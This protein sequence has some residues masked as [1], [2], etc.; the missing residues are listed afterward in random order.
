[1]LASTASSFGHAT[2]GIQAKDQKDFFKYIFSI[3]NKLSRPR[4]KYQVHFLFY[5]IFL[6][7]LSYLVLFVKPSLIELN[8]E[9][10]FSWENGSCVH[11]NAAF[12]SRPKSFTNSWSILQLII[13]IWV[14]MFALEEF[15]QAKFF[16]TKD[17]GIKQTLL[18]YLDESWNKLDAL[19]V[20]MYVVS[21]ILESYNTRTTLNASRAFLA[22]DVVLWF[23]RLLILLMIDR[24]VG[25]MLLMIQ[26]ML[27]DMVTFFSIFFVFTSAYGV[28]SFSLLKN[29]QLPLDF[30]VFRKVFHAA[31]WHVFGQMNDLDDVKEI[32]SIECIQKWT[33][34]GNFIEYAILT[35]L[36]PP[37][38]LL[39][40][41]N[42][43]LKPFN[44]ELSSE[45][46]LN[47]R[48]REAL[49]Y[50]S[51]V[52]EQA[53]KERQ[54]DVNQQEKLDLQLRQLRK[55]ISHVK[56]TCEASTIDD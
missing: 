10:A 36:L 21:I 35:P 42:Y 38:N 44:P 41:G 50:E 1:M 2:T 3:K 23:I 34:Y 24:T 7:L 25:P 37:L 16:K 43:E 53:T 46:M 12:C 11:D 51:D 52:F 39:S 47:L 20:I 31:Y 22:L 54:S 4:V 49:A 26:A 29:G 5:I 33:H 45:Q 18:L 8:E 30:A 27:N 6:C 55:M 19:C 32:H 17:N 56:L 40:T 15:R 14:F 48:R 9:M 13:N 28:A